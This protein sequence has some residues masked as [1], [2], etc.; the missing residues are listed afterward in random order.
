MFKENLSYW[1]LFVGIGIIF[2]PTLAQEKKL[3]PAGYINKYN[4]SFNGIGPK[5]YVLPAPRSEEERLTDTYNE[6][7]EFN[8]AI[9]KALYIQRFV[10]N[11]KFTTNENMVENIIKE[12]NDKESLELAN[13]YIADKNI[14]LAYSLQNN[15]ARKYFMQQSLDST[16]TLLNH[17]FK[18]AQLTNNKS[19]I[20]NIQ[21]NIASLLFLNRQF[22]KAGNLEEDYYKYVVA[23]KNNTDQ[24]NSLVKIALIQ[25]YDKDFKS[26]EN[27]IIRKAIPLFNKAKDYTGKV[28]AW[29]ALAEIYRLQNKHTE[30]Q[31]FLIQARDLTIEKNV[32]NKAAL[33]EYLLGSSKLIQENYKI[34]EKELSNALNLA[35][36]EENKYLEI[37]IIEQL[38][39]VNV[40]LKDYKEADKFLKRYWQ[41]RKELF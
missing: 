16:L 36:A 23:E 26:A 15:I 1:G 22:V 2:N 37:A 4:T 35:I 11:Y 27:G 18:N 12:K 34:S 9:Y 25:A 31:W 38:G 33:I 28:N 6:L 3:D 8:D 7:K 32:A 41:L 24:A 19:D 14:N 29:I 10:E 21:S 20:L 13:K 30:A 17:A 40:N 39:R 5:V